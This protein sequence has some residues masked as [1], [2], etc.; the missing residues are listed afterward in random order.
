MGRKVQVQGFKVESCFGVFKDCREATVTGVEQI[1]VERWT[2][3]VTETVLG[4]IG[5]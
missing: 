1:K 2:A 3:E 5:W 4:Q